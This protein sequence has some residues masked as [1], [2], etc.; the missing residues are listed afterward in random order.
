[1]SAAAAL[2]RALWKMVRGA[3]FY[4]DSRTILLIVG[5]A[6]AAGKEQPIEATNALVDSNP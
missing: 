3:Y 5:L 1:M 6:A 2:M 4:G